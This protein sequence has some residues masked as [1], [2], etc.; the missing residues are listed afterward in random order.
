MTTC[1]KRY[2]LVA[3]QLDFTIHHDLTW[4]NCL[5]LAG[6]VC[7]VSAETVLRTRLGGYTHTWWCCMWTVE[8]AGSHRAPRPPCWHS[9]TDTHPTTT[10]ECTH[11]LL[12]LLVDDDPRWM[13]S[14]LCQCSRLQSLQKVIWNNWATFNSS[15]QLLWS[16]DPFLTVFKK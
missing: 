13:S 9:S 7:W 3:F 10:S 5:R 8:T 14:P 16:N 11:A 15:S 4:R 2:L 12:S 1:L 6:S